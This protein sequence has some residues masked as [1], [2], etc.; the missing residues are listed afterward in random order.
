MSLSGRACQ[1]FSKLRTRSGKSLVSQVHIG[2][3]KEAVSEV[4][5]TDENAIQLLSNQKLVL[6]IDSLV[7]PASAIDA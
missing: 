2:T 7:I 3:S 4:Q 6:P 1:R 5:N